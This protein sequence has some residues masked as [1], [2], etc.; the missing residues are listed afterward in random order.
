M[1]LLYAGGI[2]ANMRTGGLHGLSSLGWAYYFD[3]QNGLGTMSDVL[4]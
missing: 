2:I 1:P 3:D 4:S